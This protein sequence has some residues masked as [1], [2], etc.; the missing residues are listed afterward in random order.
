MEVFE[1]LAGNGEIITI[2]CDAKMPREESRFRVYNDK[3]SIELT[4]TAVADR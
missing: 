2:Q 4:K 1:K 3:K